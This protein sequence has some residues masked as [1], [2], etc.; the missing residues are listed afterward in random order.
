[1]ILVAFGANLPSAIG[2]PSETYQKL[3][4]ILKNYGV[5]VLDASSLHVTKPVPA[6]DQPDYCNAVLL[7]DTDLGAR[8]LL[9]V[10]L[11]VESDL[12]RVRGEI[13]AA[14]GVDLDL[15]A[16]HDHILEVEGLSLPHP[17]MHER[18]FVLYPLQEIAAD[19]VHP[20][21]KC[22]VSAMIAGL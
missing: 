2:S 6:S 1:M 14:R 13:N 17:R 21:S 22:S 10:L 15:I 3:P 20:V 16:Y 5:R 18:G 7:L 12:G 11:Q 19:W 4:D 8:E 9:L